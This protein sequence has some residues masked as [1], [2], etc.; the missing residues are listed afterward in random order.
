[1]ST[2]TYDWAPFEKNVE[3]EAPGEGPVKIKNRCS[4]EVEFSAALNIYLAGY[5]RN[6]EL[7][8]DK[9]AHRLL[10]NQTPRGHGTAE[11]SM[12]QPLF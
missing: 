8:A 5:R 4:R 11:M 2:I 3:A 6:R 1:M 9:T 7:I 12:C 10:K